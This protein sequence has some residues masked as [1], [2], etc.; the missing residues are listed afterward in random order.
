MP[1][2]PKVKMAWVLFV[3]CVLTLTH[4]KDILLV[5][6]FILTLAVVTGCI[7]F[8]LA[9]I[10][11]S[12]VLLGGAVFVAVVLKQFLRPKMSH[13]FNPAASG[14]FA[15]SLFGLPITWWGVSWGYLPLL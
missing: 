3:L 2:K 6:R 5:E 1:W 14:L 15:A 9:D 13:I 10:D 11:A 7:I 4:F 8:L 12:F